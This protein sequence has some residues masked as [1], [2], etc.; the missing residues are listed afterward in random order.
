M[1]DALQQA[2]AANLTRGSMLRGGRSCVGV[3]AAPVATVAANA[4]HTFTIVI[5]EDCVLDRLFIDGPAADLPELVVTDIK[6]GG[7][8]LISSAPVPASMFGRDAVN[9]PLFGHV[10]GSDSKVSVTVQNRD[11]T[12]ATGILTCGF[13][14]R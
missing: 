10:V 5:D 14:A 3:G 4:S 1:A 8:S 9:S 13:S 7:D 6:I 12:N 2:L 11:G